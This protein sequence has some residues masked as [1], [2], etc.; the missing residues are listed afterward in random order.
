MYTFNFW[1]YIGHAYNSKMSNSQLT[2]HNRNALLTGIPASAA[3]TGTGA[4][5]KG[6]TLQV[7]QQHAAGHPTLS[8]DFRIVQGDIQ[9]LVTQHIPVSEQKQKLMAQKLLQHSK[10]SFE[11]VRKL[12]TNEIGIEHNADLLNTHLFKTTEWSVIHK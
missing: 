12:I 1:P 7:R 2:I 5:T 3:I 4:F 10:M 8:G 9:T 11:N 6:I